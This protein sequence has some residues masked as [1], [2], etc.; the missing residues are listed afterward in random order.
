MIIR[1]SG[2]K[3][4]LGMTAIKIEMIPH[5][6]APVVWGKI[7]TW[8]SKDHFLHLK[9]EYYDESGK[10]INR[11]DSFARSGMWETGPF[12][13]NSRW[14]LWKRQ[15]HETTMI[16]ENIKFNIHIDDDFSRS[17]I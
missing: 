15:D 1:S 12:R 9:N 17:R 3:R 5:E 8:I 16:F 13:R 10:L 11:E 4:F 6:N 14:F 2:R 7:I